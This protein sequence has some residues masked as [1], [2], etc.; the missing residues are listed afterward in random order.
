MPNIQTFNSSDYVVRENT[1]KKKIL[2]ATPAYDRKVS[3]FY[4]L[5]I[6]DTVRELEKLGHHVDVQIP[7]DSSLLTRARNDILQ[8]FMEMESDYLLMIDSDLAWNAKYVLDLL[9]ADKE[10]S[11]G[12]YPSRDGR[13]YK[14]EP[15]LN[16]DGSLVICPN[17]G[18]IKAK[19]VPAGFLLLKRSAIEKM[20]EQFPEYYYEP[21]NPLSY[22]GKGYCLFN[23]EVFHGEFWGEDFTF[24]RR[25]KEARV[26]IWI[27]PYIPF[28][29]AGVE[30]R[31]TDI[32]SNNREDSVQ[33][34]QE[35]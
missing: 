17:T 23:T 30:G 32:L 8:K 22:H 26:D 28:S 29:H 3:V 7:M 34:K 13:G 2:I 4:M 1:Q 33:E 18:M 10:F 19:Y 31:L 6:L 5:C 20:Q 15:Y 11:C 35:I 14:F 21:K 16:D 24:C 9:E 25:A 12:V 27:N